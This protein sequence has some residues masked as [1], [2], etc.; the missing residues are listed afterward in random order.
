MRRS[1]RTSPRAR[2]R[3]P[4][5]E[6]DAP[7]RVARA[8]RGDA[9]AVTGQ[10]LGGA[11]RKVEAVLVP[12]QPRAMAIPAPR[13]AGRRPPRVSP[14]ARP[15]RPSC[16]AHRTT[17]A[18]RAWARSWPPRQMPSTGTRASTALGAAGRPRPEQRVAVDV[19]HR[20]AAAQHQDAVG[21][22]QAGQRRRRRAAA[23]RRSSARRRAA[24]AP[25]GR[26]TAR[27]GCA[28]RRASRRDGAE[29][30]A[31][32]VAEDD[33]AV[34]GAPPPRRQ[35]SRALQRVDARPL[36]QHDR[37]VT[38]ADRAGRGTA[39]RRRARR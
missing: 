38:Q 26:G 29:L 36:R 4:R 6:L 13:P 32:R 5:V 34:R 23:A 15:R 18:P 30:D 14:R 17:C 31:P 25:R 7:R 37:P 10:Q 39:A 2:D 24:G 21:L 1:G 8:E 28:G 35:R 12:V 3:R 19:A 20:L 22:V 16:A 11:G 27:A 33:H 9:G